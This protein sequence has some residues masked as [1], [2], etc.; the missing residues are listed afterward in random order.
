MPRA[1]AA[2]V[3]TSRLTLCFTWVCPHDPAKYRYLTILRYFGPARKGS[4]AVSGPKMRR[5]P[6]WRGKRRQGR[7]LCACRWAATRFLALRQPEG[8]APAGAPP[9]QKTRPR[10]GR[11]PAGAM[12]FLYSGL[13]R[14]KAA[15]ARLAALSAPGA[16]QLLKAARGA[17]IPAVGVLQPGGAGLAFGVGRKIPLWLAF[18][19]QTLR[20]RTLPR[21]GRAAAVRAEAP[22]SGCPAGGGCR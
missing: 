4:G 10:A 1:P 5:T 18:R 8:F 19:A 12:R 2:P 16:H 22:A 20:R 15:S 13:F 9:E 14:C 3:R 21:C 17:E 7:T 11:L 6:P